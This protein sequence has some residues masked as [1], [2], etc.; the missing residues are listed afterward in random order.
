MARVKAIKRVA[1]FLRT[2]HTISM[3]MASNRRFLKSSSNEQGQTVVEYILLLS[4]VFTLI[5]TFLNSNFYQTMFGSNGQLATN[6]KSQSEF[7][8]RHG[9]MRGRPAGLMPLQ[10]NGASS[11][12]SYTKGGESRFYG[13]RNPYR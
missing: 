2:R 3:D 8:Y 13:P 6:M 11:H 4:V 12:P 10:Y 1:F 7:G 9:F 5:Y